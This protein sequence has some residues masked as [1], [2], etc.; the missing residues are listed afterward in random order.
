MP[1][2]AR[3]LIDNDYAG[4]PDGLFQLAHHV[5]SPSVE[6]PFVVASRLPA[7]MGPAAIDAVRR[8]VNAAGVVLRLLG[9]PIPV[10]GGADDGLKLGTTPDLSPTTEAIIRE[11]MRADTDLP[12]F[13]AAGGGLTEIAA[14]YLHEPAIADR[15]TLV[16]IGGN[17]YDTVTGPGAGQGEFNIAIDPVAAQVVF[18]S[19]VPIWQVPQPVYGQCLVSWAELEAWVRPSGD[20]G[21]HL[22]DELRRFVDLLEAQFHLDLGETVILGDN[23]LVLLTALQSSFDPDP[24]TSESS[25]RPRPVLS[26]N[27]EYDGERPDLPEVRVF[28][29]LDTRLMLADMYA[30][31]AAFAGR[32]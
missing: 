21:T 22:L 31:F 10:L 9:S 24:S 13:Y 5:L 29:R 15:I 7:M 1:V 18:A 17:S 12:L 20:L 19:P 11:A 25:W 2:R 6:I 28:T 14:A 26:S 32:S 30:K 16:W 3:V 8:G 23:P 27:G 4:N